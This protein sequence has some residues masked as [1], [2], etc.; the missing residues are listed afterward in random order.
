MVDNVS[1]RYCIS[2][3]Y[4]FGLLSLSQLP[5]NV[6]IHLKNILL[7]FI[8]FGGTGTEILYQTWM[9]KSYSTT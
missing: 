8:Y 2:G 3:T 4:C 1:F 7:G 6:A 5:Q 9:F